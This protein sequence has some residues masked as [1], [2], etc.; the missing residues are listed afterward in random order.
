MKVKLLTLTFLVG[1][2]SLSSASKGLPPL[3]SN[4]ESL[5]AKAMRRDQNGAEDFHNYLTD[6]MT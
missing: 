2:L 5:I 1:S 6:N 3:D 4:N